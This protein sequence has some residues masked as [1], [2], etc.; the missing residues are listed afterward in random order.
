MSFLAFEALV[1]VGA[2]PQGLVAD[3]NGETSAV[4]LWDLPLVL[5]SGCPWP[6]SRALRLLLLLLP[7]PKGLLVVHL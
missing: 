4:P 6:W 7:A 1:F 2:F 3:T 5:H